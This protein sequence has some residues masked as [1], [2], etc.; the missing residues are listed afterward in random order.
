M[1]MSTY[2]KAGQVHTEKDEEID[3]NDLKNN[4]KRLNG[5]TSMLIKVFQIGKDW[6]HEERMR[7]SMLSNSLSTCPLWLLYKCHKGIDP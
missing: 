5:H 1:S 2:I 3:L 7:E 4:Q 6:N